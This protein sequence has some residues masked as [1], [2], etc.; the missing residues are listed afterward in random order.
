MMITWTVRVLTMEGNHIQVLV[1][2]ALRLMAMSHD[3]L[4]S[5]LETSAIRSLPHRYCFSP[6][7][8]QS[9]LKETVDILKGQNNVMHSF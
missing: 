2:Y 9:R 6:L 3:H 7:S 8:Q 5:E 4:R 1:L